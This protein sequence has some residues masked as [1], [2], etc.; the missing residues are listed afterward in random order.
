[1]KIKKISKAV[2]DQVNR[3]RYDL[4]RDPVKVKIRTCCRC[5]RKFESIGDRSCNCSHEVVEW[6]SW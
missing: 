2:L 4:G 1:M 3:A 6:G 5:G